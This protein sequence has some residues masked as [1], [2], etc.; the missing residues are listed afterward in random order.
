MTARVTKNPR[1]TT[2]TGWEPM[3]V[4][5]NLQDPVTSQRLSMKT[6]MI[7]ITISSQPALDWSAWSTLL[8]PDMVLP[9]T[10]TVARVEIVMFTLMDT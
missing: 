10:P 5:S 2:C 3:Y 7:G 8:S 1:H 6:E 9:T 4:M